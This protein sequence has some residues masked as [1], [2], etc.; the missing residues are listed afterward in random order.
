M[1]VLPEKLQELIDTLRGTCA[2]LAETCEHM[3]FMEDD[4]TQSQLE[5]IDDQIFCCEGCGWWD[6]ISELSDTEA[7]LCRDCAE[8]NESEA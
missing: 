6:E 5:E 8:D 3:G 7:Q 4:L 2:G 1:K